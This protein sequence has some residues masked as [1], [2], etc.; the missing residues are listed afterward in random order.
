MISGESRDNCKGKSAFPERKESDQPAQR[1]RAGDDPMAMLKPL[2]RTKCPKGHS[3][4]GDN[5]YLYKRTRGCRIC[6][7]LQSEAYKSRRT[8]PIRVAKRRTPMTEPTAKLVLAAIRGGKTLNSICGGRRDGRYV[9][10][11]RIT[12]HLAYKFYCALNPDFFR[13]ASEVLT[14]NTK[15]ATAKKGAHLRNLMQCKHGH[16]LADDNIFRMPDGSRKCKTCA[17]QR[18]LAPRPAS[19]EQIQQLTAALNVGKTV[20]EICWGKVAGKKVATPILGFRK[21]KFHRLLNPDFDR[22]YLAATADHSSKGHRRSRLKPEQVR[23]E[24]VREQNNDYHKIRA[25]LPANYPEKDEVVCLIM[26]DLLTGAINRDQVG[27]RLQ[28]YISVNNSQV[29]T[30]YPKFGPHKLRSL[31][32]PLYDDGNSTLGD[33]AKHTLW[34]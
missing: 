14:E 8:D 25:M 4:S 6:R 28:S 19:A 31:D 18:D 5:L 23:L 12:D 26:E 3:L 13:E 2:A 34:D 22:F 10:G 24:I 1:L 7:Q 11:E 17:K 15:I 16:S 32:A 30:Q 27:K 29:P 20:G 9:P 33:M 21:L